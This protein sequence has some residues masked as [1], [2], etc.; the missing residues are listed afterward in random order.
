MTTIPSIENLYVKI[1]IEKLKPFGQLTY[2]DVIPSKNAIENF[3]FQNVE[4]H[5]SNYGGEIMLGW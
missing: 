5:I 1:L 2:V 4:E 3:C